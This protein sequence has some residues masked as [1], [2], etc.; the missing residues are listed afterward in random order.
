MHEKKLMRL[1]LMIAAF[2]FIGLAKSQ[3]ITVLD[4]STKSG[5]DHVYIHNNTQGVY[6]D[7][8]GK[9]DLSE[10]EGEEYSFRHVGY[11]SYSI[12]SKDLRELN[13]T[14]YLVQSVVSVNEIVVNVN[15]W[16]QSAKEVP[17][18]VKLV[19]KS[20]VT[21]ENP[22][23]SA[24]LLG[25]SQNVFIQKS[26]M[27][28]GSPMIRG[29]STS[30]VLLVVD[31]VRM[32]TAIFR[33]G[34]VQNVISLDPN[35]VQNTEILFGPGAAIYGSD[36]LGGV[37]AFTTLAP[38]FAVD[39]PGLTSLNSFIRLSSA[40]SEITGHID[41]NFG[42]KKWAS[43]TSVSFSEFGD[44]RMGSN[45]PQEYLRP[46]YQTTIRGVDSVVQ[47]SD[48]QKQVA[49]AYNQLNVMQKVAFKPNRHSRWDLGIH[50][51][52]SSNVP[53]Y[54]RLIRYRDGG[55]R[56]SEWYYGPQT[57]AMVN[58]GSTYSRPTKVFDRFKWN[59]AYQYF[60]ESR[61]SRNF[62][63]QELRVQTEKVDAYSLN[64]DFDKKLST[65]TGLFYGAEMV[66]NK[67]GSQAH[68]KNIFTFEEN[69]IGTRYPDGSTWASGALYATIKHKFDNDFILDAGLRY[70]H[71]NSQGTIDTQFYP[72]PFNEIKNN[73][74]ALTGMAGL[75][76]VPSSGSRVYMHLSSG[77]RAPNIDDM[78]K[79][80]DPEPNTV[81]VPNPTLQAEYLYNGE[82]GWVQKFSQNYSFEISAF[83]SYLDNAMVRRP[84]T[85]NGHDSIIYDGVLSQV[86]ALQNTD[87]ATIY[88]VQ[89]GVFGDVNSF[90][91]AKANINYTR[92]QSSD[93][94]GL[95]HVAPLFGQVG[96][97]FK[98]GWFKADLNWIYN[99]ELTADR[100]APSEQGKDYLYLTDEN[101]QTYSPSW[102]TLNLKMSFKLNHYLE[103]LGGIENILDERYRPY[104]SGIAAA[105]RNFYITVRAY[106]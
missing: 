51:T 68:E 10:L 60:Q 44:L 26:Q 88:G 50:F 83:Y 103:L 100:M 13:F 106:L 48:P 1:V 35:A 24:D 16:E 82:I 95:R 22:Q 90:L 12:S 41:F 72:L 81:I 40:N 20:Q 6:T 97:I 31:G 74:G 29:F 80:F 4:A 11:Q 59:I 94:Q 62:G 70:S 58:L 75:T 93:G 71:V 76:W 45:G 65:K 55:L 84:Y 79:V 77:F 36:A 63:T 42:N 15:K 101:G 86:V 85:F 99:G 46:E 7:D 78:G 73:S 49:S 30:R 57:W 47:N 67:V 25:V 37:M 9:A 105:G 53:R 54:D 34:N 64:F 33:E 96:L 61:N 39:K 92:G 17:T 28:G 2:L 32:N 91:Q 23:T 18:F 27:G 5:I 38:N 102:S 19:G 21:F 52:T 3:I 98:H 69:A 66:L 56:Y 8:K 14:V 87:Y 43:T 104:S 89:A